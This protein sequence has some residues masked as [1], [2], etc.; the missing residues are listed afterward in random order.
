MEQEGERRSGKSGWEGQ[1]R[2]KRYN[3]R[4]QVMAC[5]N[6]FPSGAHVRNPGRGPGDIVPQKLEHFCKYTT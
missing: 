3:W 5:G 6:I 4:G 1:G 2:S